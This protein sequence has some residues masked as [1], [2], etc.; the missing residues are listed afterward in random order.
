MPLNYNLK[1]LQENE[2][3]GPI[4]TNAIIKHLQGMRSLSEFLSI[5]PNG[6]GSVNF[7]LDA[8]SL[9]KVILGMV[10]DTQE[11]EFDFK[12]SIS[13]GNLHVS[14]GKVYF[15]NTSVSVSGGTFDDDDTVHIALTGSASGSISGS[16]ATGSVSRVITNA[17]TMLL[18]LLT[19]AT[20]NGEKV[21]KYYHVGDYVFDM[22]PPAWIS[23]F[24]SDSVQAL[25][26][27]ANSFAPVWIDYGQCEE[28]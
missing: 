12:G 25:S 14:S 22:L 2:I 23:G 19:T 8:N 5:E 17:T 1:P 20:I 11:L 3:A 24:R 21:V 28:E 15:P 13:N 9:I 10:E 6:Q 27:D 16:L 26:H 4:T 18:P 7:D